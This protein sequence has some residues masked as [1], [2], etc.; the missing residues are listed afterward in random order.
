VKLKTT[1]LY[2][3]LALL[4]AS[5]QS[6]EEKPSNQTLTQEVSTNQ[7]GSPEF[8]QDPFALPE[9]TGIPQNQ[10]PFDPSFDPN[11]VLDPAVI[12]PTTTIPSTIPPI[13]TTPITPTTTAPQD[14]SCAAQGKLTNHFSSLKEC[15]G[16]RAPEEYQSMEK[17]IE[18]F[19]SEVDLRSAI[20]NLGSSA[21]FLEVGITSTDTP[22]SL[23]KL[24]PVGSGKL[25]IFIKVANGF[26]HFSLQ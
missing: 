10:N 22:N 21:S 3:S 8:A 25:V 18:L 16:E 1:F 4:A 6:I 17:A 13:T 19:G 26:H 7:F 5:C 15:F 11:A 24:K 14:L 12:N 23:D 20:N 2:I 9:V